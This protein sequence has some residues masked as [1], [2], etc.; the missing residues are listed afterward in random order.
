MEKQK[1]LSNDYFYSA[2]AALE[3]AE[4]ARLFFKFLCTEKETQLIAQRLYVAKLLSENKVYS[5]IV[6]QTGASSATVSR[7]KRAMETDREYFAKLLGKLNE[8]L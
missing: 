7:V 1:R 4:E 3:N 2:A 6:A 8:Q 5:E